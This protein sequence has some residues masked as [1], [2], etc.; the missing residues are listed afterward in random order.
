MAVLWCCKSHIWSQG[1][2]LSE[3][4]DDSPGAIDCL[5]S[6][7]RAQS[8]CPTVPLSLLPNPK[9]QDLL[10]PVTSKISILLTDLNIFTTRI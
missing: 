4:V 2:V 1:P 5:P 7:L 9:G 3:M 8:V 10:R 6:G